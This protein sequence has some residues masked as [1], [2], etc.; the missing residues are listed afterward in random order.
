MK[1]SEPN[2]IKIA[3]VITAA[4]RWVVALLAAEGFALP[5]AWLGWWIVLSAFL[6]LGMAVVEGFAFSYML[7][8]WRNQR[9]KAS[10]NIFWLAL[11]SAVVFILVITPSIS[12]NVRGV[13]VSEILAWDPVLHVWAAL[14]AL[15]T[16]VI[17]GGVGYAEKQTETHESARI[18][19]LKGQLKAAEDKVK[20]AEETLKQREAALNAELDQLNAAL[21][22]SEAARRKAEKQAGDLAGLFSEVKK[23]QILAIYHRWSFLQPS[24]IAE[25]VGTSPSHVSGTLKEI[26]N[27]ANHK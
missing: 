10:N 21:T 18:T 25:M 20:Q 8:A 1:I 9:D 3:A 12:A 15:S 26:L 11:A 6:S 24:I 7:T 14:V 2:A 27:G 17:V 19:Q 13:T 22:A 5:A 4:P 16:I 23:E